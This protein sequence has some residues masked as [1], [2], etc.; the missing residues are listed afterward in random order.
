M[1]PFSCS[2]LKRVFGFVVLFALGIFF[3][4]RK[5]MEMK[6]QSRLKGRK[7]AKEGKGRSGNLGGG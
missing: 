2:F 1:L 7:E 4:E 5:T 6:F 3:G